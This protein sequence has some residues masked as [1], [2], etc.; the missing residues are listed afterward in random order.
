LMTAY[1]ITYFFS[2]P[3]GASSKPLKEEDF[4]SGFRRNQWVA[5]GSA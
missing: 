4:C 2:A 1:I 3:F 5:G